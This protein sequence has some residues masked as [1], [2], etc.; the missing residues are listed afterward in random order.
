MKVNRTNVKSFLAFLTHFLESVF[1]RNATFL[2][3][4]ISINE[5]FMMSSRYMKNEV[6]RYVIKAHK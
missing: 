6:M 1:F 5:E 3:D 2:I 4:K